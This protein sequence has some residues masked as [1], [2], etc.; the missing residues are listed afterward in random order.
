MAET[1]NPWKET[2]DNLYPQAM[3]FFLPQAARRGDW[4]RDYEA[5]EG[6]LRPFLP[7]SQTGPLRVDKLVKVWQLQTAAGEVL[8]AGAPQEEYYHFEVQY[9]K[10]D[11][12]EKRMSE[13]NDVARVHLHNHVIST[14]ILGDE[15]PGWRP[16]VY[17][18]EKDGCELTF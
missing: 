1:D 4:T 10:E 3:R 12:F 8:E 5:L 11:D 14:A 9:R 16:E 7:T 6:E 2:L 15:D 17:H 18:W 13:Y